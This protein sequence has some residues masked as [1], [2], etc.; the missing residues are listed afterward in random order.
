[1]QKSEKDISSP[2]VRATE[3]LKYVAF[4]NTRQK[5]DKPMTDKNMGSGLNPIK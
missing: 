5:I 1:V 4:R 2:G 3:K